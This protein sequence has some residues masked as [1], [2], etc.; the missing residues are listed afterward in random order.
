[1]LINNLLRGVLKGTVA[2]VWNR[3][4]MIWEMQLYLEG[5][6]GGLENLYRV[7]ISSVNL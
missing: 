6:A 7:Y 5:A 2:P 3:L 1:M 4:R